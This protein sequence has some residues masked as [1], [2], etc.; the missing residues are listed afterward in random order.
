MGARL[1]SDYWQ[2]AN[3]DRMQA[4][5][6]LKVQL[7]HAIPRDVTF[8]H[9]TDL[10]NPASRLEGLRAHRRTPMDDVQMPDLWNP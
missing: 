8:V 9:Y 3:R 7:G 1:L 4:T 5:L 10:S 2:R 6:W